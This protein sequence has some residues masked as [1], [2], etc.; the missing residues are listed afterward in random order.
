MENYLLTEFEAVY[1]VGSHGDYWDMSSKSYGLRGRLV[2]QYAW[3]IPTPKALELVASHSPLVE[4]G[5]GT[6]YWA[7]LLGDM[8]ADIVAYDIA[9]P[10][11][12]TNTYRHK[13]TYT[14]VLEGNHKVLKRHPD[15]ALFLCWPPYSDP[16]ATECLRAYQGSTLVY[17]GEGW[18]GCN[19]DRDFWKLIHEEWDDIT[20]VD[21]P[22]FSGLH[23]GL[24]VYQRTAVSVERAKRRKAKNAAKRARRALRGWR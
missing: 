19:G 24:T 22:Q 20:A 23:D 13:R 5:A 2:E 4:I 17:I 3:A 18:G 12:M 16:M 1:G 14:N 21:I 11:R 15:R 9:P 8:G 6:G 7:A 10:D